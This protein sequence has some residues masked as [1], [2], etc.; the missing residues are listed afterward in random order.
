MSKSNQQFSAYIAMRRFGLGVGAVD[1]DTVAANPIQ[2]LKNQIDT[3]VTIPDAL[4]KF[5][6]SATIVADLHK[7]RR[8]SAEN[9]RKAK[10]KHYRENFKHEV[11]AKA[12]LLATTSAPFQERL[13]RFWSNHFT[14]SRA[15]PVIGPII[16]AYERE[17]IRPNFLGKF[18]DLLLAVTSHI[19]MLSYLDNVVSIGPNSRVGK[20][21]GKSLNE[22]LA[23]EILELHT[24]GVNGDYSQQDVTEFAR[25]LTGWTHGS[26]GRQD[27]PA[28]RGKFVFR[29]VLH[30]PGSKVVL[31]KT[32]REEGENEVKRILRDLAQH[33]STA[34]HISFK[35]ARHFIA[36]DPPKR[37]VELLS[38]A[39]LASRGDLKHV[40]LTLIR[41]EEAWQISPSKY[42]TPQEL[43]I[44][45]HR[46]LGVSRVTR[47]NFVLPLKLLGQNPFEAPSPK[48]WPDTE[49]DWLGPE[50]LMHRVEWLRA[51]VNQQ[52]PR[53]S[54]SEF[55]ERTLGPYLSERTARMI[56]RAPSGEAAVALA[57]ISP[58]FQRR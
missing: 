2:W 20:R 31:G 19:A 14:V 43:V 49:N 33:P 16:P 28:D 47:H 58:E 45:T 42:L 24:L 50:S 10:Q 48:G 13:V 8:Q 11:S 3:G 12:N 7:A 55:A 25:A 54:P 57:L 34:Q 26:V 35:L 15:K 22:N 23:R 1:I 5:P 9:L 27:D 44:A 6:G 32:Y 53:L 51:T 18:E 39:W 41:L 29:E 40:L 52:R 21:R 30:E 46:A 37:A 56:E 36:D 4:I 38:E 17:A